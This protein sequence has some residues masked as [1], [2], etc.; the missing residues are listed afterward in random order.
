MAG[1]IDTIVPMSSSAAL[2]ASF[3]LRTPVT[4]HKLLQSEAFKRSIS[5]NNLCCQLLS[6][7]LT[8]N[9]EDINSGLANSPLKVAVDKIASFFSRELCGLVLFG[10]R[11]R[12]EAWRN[13]DFDLLIL[14]EK[15]STIDRAL[16]RRWDE[17]GISDEFSPHFVHQPRV[18]KIPSQGPADMTQDTSP[19][20][21]IF[22]EAAL[23]GRILYDKNSSIAELMHQIRFKIAAGQFVRNFVHGQPSWQST[24]S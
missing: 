12:G 19:L 14:L 16:Y 17:L 5:L 4:L 10:S 18:K 13:S 6:A 9:V 11:A 23:E 1:N 24:R 3:V 21:A 20:N 8:P 22:L 15:S 2:K 7:G